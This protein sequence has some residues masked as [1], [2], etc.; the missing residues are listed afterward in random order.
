MKQIQFIS[1]LPKS[2]GSLLARLLAQ[3]PDVSVSKN[4]TACHEAMYAVRNSWNI[5]KEHQADEA[6]ANEAN[7]QRVLNGMINSYCL[8]DNDV[9]FDKGRSWLSLLEM[10]EF[11]LGRRVKVLVPV[12]TIK[13]I[14]A[15]YEIEHREKAHK[16]QSLASYF[17]SLSVEGRAEHLTSPEGLIGTAYT[18]IKDAMQ[19]G[20]GDRLFLVDYDDLIQNPEKSMNQV[21]AWLDMDAPNHDFS[22][23]NTKA[24]NN[25]A[26]RILGEELCEKLSH[27]EFWREKTSQQQTI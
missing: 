1:G 5:W 14:V 17:D 9:H 8:S 11:A 16:T 24:Q 13:D 18:K 21:W 26:E 3:D 20:L 15:S 10:A 25:T 19:R 12:R 22:I 2:G 6:L 4:N 7:L 27:T 23:V